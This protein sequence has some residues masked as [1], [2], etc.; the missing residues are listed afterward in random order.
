MIVPQSATSFEISNVGPVPISISN[1][2][3]KVAGNYSDGSDPVNTYNNVSLLD[4]KAQGMVNSTGG[5]LLELW[6]L[7]TPDCSATINRALPNSTNKDRWNSTSNRAKYYHHINWDSNY[8]IDLVTFS[9]L[10]VKLN[11]G[12]F[13]Q[14]YIQ[15]QYSRFFRREPSRLHGAWLTDY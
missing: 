7:P 8:T 1:I 4:N 12:D 3:F 6:F 15:A 14:V 5:P 2:T 10:N 11:P 13:I 9:G